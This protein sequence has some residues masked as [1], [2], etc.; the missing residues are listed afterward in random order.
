MD[1]TADAHGNSPM[2]LFTADAH[3]NAPMILFIWQ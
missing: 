3:G 2:I 1:A